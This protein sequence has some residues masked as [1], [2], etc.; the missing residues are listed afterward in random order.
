VKY[1]LAFLS[2]IEL[3]VMTNPDASIS[4]TGR[5]ELVPRDCARQILSIRQGLQLTQARLAHQI[6]AAGK[7]V[8]YQWESE[9]RKPSPVF[10]GRIQK[11]VE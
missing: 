4:A 6:G 8:V 7:A 5:H 1:L 10:W 11:L 9:K 3:M 2:G